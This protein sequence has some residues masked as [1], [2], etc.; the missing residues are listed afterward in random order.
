[1]GIHQLLKLIPS[2]VPRQHFGING[3][4]RSEPSVIS[5]FKQRLSSAFPVYKFEQS[6]HGYHYV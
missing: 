4:G 1:M 2:E 3:K 6:T 5:A